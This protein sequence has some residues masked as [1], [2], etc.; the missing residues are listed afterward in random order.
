MGRWEHSREARH[1][2]EQRGYELIGTML[3]RRRRAASL[4]QRQLQY[5]AGID[6]A[7]ISRLEN[8]KQ[9]GLRWSRFAFLV[10]VLDG[11]DGSPDDRAAPWWE[12]A[13]I[14]PPAYALESLELDALLSLEPS[15]EGPITRRDPSGL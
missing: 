6:Q 2:I 15:G 10:G 14:T 4:T 5:A 8:G 11:L 1:G 9:Y 13:G 12:S 3:R 7:V